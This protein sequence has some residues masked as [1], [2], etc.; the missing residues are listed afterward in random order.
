[1]NSIFLQKDYNERLINAV[2]KIS[3]KSN[4]IYLYRILK[5]VC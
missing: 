3:S 5:I 4:I 2:D 1:M